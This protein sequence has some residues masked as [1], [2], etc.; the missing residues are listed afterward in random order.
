MA[1]HAHYKAESPLV[2][3]VV[4]LM[5]DLKLRWLTPHR[6]ARGGKDRC[7]ACSSPAECLQTRLVNVRK[8]HYISKTTAKQASRARREGAH[9]CNAKK[10]SQ[11]GAMHHLL[12]TQ[13]AKF[14]NRTSKCVCPVYDQLL[15]DRAGGGE[16]NGARMENANAHIDLSTLDIAA[17]QSRLSELG[18]Y[19]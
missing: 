4:G 15:L 2:K 13:C 16:Y 18:S 12:R 8:P 17:M 5:Y 11:T 14:S 7:A 3:I 9:P 6:S 1:E 10:R 19:L